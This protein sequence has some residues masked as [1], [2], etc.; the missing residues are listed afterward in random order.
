MILVSRFL[1]DLQAVGSRSSIALGEGSQPVYST[2]M[3]A[4]ETIT[5]AHR[6]T[7]S[8]GETLNPLEDVDESPSSP[9]FVILGV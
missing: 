9:H 1:M 2:E 8:I 6:M 7:G 3:S 5:F 4:V